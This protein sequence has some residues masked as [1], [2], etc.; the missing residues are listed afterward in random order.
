ML[1]FLVFALAFSSCVTLGTE[2]TQLISKEVIAGPCVDDEV[3]GSVAPAGAQRVHL[4]LSVR[5]H[6]PKVERETWAAETSSQLDDM[7]RLVIAL[8]STVV[9]LGAVSAVLIYAAGQSNSS[10]LSAAVPVTAYACALAVGTGLWLLLGAHSVSPGP[11]QL[12]ENELPAERFTHA[13]VGKVRLASGAVV[14]LDARGADVDRAEVAG[15]KVFVGDSVV[16]IDGIVQ[17]P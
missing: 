7:P 15:G 4:S 8:A 6:C 14:Q 5:Q 10:S 3:S 9:L 13:F 11:N 1:R 2:R 17:L 12:L 16:P